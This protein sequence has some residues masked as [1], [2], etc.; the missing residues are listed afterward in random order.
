MAKKIAPSVRSRC[1]N[2]GQV[3]HSSY[4]AAC[5]QSERDGHP[6]TVRHFLHDLFHEFLHIDGKIFRTLGTLFFQPGKL[7]EEYWAGRVSSSI[8]PIRIFL[9]IVFLHV[10][11]SPGEGPLSHQVSVSQSPA[12]G[13][14]KV[15]II[16][17]LI[18]SE[19]IASYM[20]WY[21][22]QEDRA[23]ASEEERQR[24]SHEFEKAYAVIRYTSVLLFALGAWLFYRRQQP[25]YINHLIGGLHFYSFWY[26]LATLASLPAR[27]NP[28]WN[29]LPVLA[30]IYLYLAVGR[31]FHERWYIQMA[32]TITL[33]LFV[34]LA[35][36]GLGYAAARWIER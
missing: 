30:L 2:C 18:D 16:S 13:D 10:L 6:P 35:E 34:H 21:A 23:L 15:N 32:K 26:A 22:E 17:G 20:P 9:F 24:F 5:G 28:L 3:L 8:R 29:N 31:L 25:Y 7:T 19:V 1:R 4:C 27:L 12:G 36:L 14:L 33:Y 11:V